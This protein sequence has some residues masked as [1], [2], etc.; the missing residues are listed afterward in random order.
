[1]RSRLSA[2]DRP[3]VSEPEADQ[4]GSAVVDFVLVMLLLLP[5]V[6]GIVQVGL[7]LH[8]RNTLTAAASD[9]A[10]AGAPLGARPADAVVRTRE[11]I[12]GALADRFAEDVSA[13]NLV[14][15]GVPTVEVDVRAGVPALGLF[16]PAVP[17]QVDGH[18]VKEVAP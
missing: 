5:L 2:A 8:V 18:A 4:H 1:M 13:R 16:G 14:Q 6:M 10:R 17:L 15:S 11:L 9:G 12:R 3:D 7:V